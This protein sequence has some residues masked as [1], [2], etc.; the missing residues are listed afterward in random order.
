MHWNM[1]NNSRHLHRWSDAQNEQFCARTERRPE[2]TT[3][4]DYRSS[5]YRYSSDILSDRGD[6]G[7]SVQHFLFR[8]IR[9]IAFATRSLS[10]AACSQRYVLTNVKHSGCRR[11]IDSPKYG[12][13][14][15]ILAI[16]DNQMRRWRAT[17]H[18]TT[19]RGRRLAEVVECPRTTY[20]PIAAISV[21]VFN[22][23][24]FAISIRSHPRRIRCQALRVCR[25]MYSRM[26]SIPV[27]VAP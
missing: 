23:F 2:T 18:A 11:V 17:S 24:H 25:D 15:E 9:T 8:D 12:K 27:A 6:F 4:E 21:V 3:D 19:R 26:L 7:G 10:N 5:S 1:K 14:L 22:V 13:K 16:T 20:L